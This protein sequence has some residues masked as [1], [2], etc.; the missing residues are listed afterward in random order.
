V[1]TGETVRTFRG[2]QDWVSAVAFSP[3]GRFALSGSHD[4]T[5]ML[6]DVATGVAVRTFKGHQ[7]SV[8]AVAFSPDGRFALS[9]SENN[10]LMLWDVTTGDSV[11]RLVVAAAV[12]AVD[13]RR[14]KVVIGLQNGEV[15]FLRVRL[16]E[17]TIS[18]APTKQERSS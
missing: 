11:C 10:T 5:L 12:L 7:K 2:H 4:D 9:G 1:A 3:D 14:D 18:V 16:P 8:R 17:G 15:E 13:W 6:W